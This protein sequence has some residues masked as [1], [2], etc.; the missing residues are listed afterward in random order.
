MAKK[1]KKSTNKRRHLRRMKEDAAKDEPG[2]WLGRGNRGGNKDGDPDGEEGFN[3]LS[4]NAKGENWDVPFSNPQGMAS[5]RKE[6]RTSKKKV[7][8]EKNAR[9]SEGHNLTFLVK[10]AAMLGGNEYQQELDRKRG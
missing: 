1:K 9:K 6:E 4:I 2:K 8:R 7:S 3:Q 10:S 5:R